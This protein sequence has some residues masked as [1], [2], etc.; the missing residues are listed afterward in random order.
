[1]K[2][3]IFN[4]Y[5]DKGKPSAERAGGAYR[6]AT[7]L[8][9][10]GWD[11]EVVDYLVYWNIEELTKLFD[12]RYSQGKI[13]WVG[14]S[15]TWNFRH[16]NLINL[17]FYIKR[18]YPDVK[19]IIGGNT[20]FNIDVKADYYVYGFGEYAADAILKYEFSNGTKPTGRPHWSG[21]AVDALSFYPAWPLDDYTLEYEDRDYL[22]PDDVVSVEIG[23]GCRFKCKYCNFPVLGLKEDTSMSEETM[24]K[25]FSSMYDRWGITTYNI[26]DE[27]VNER[28]SKLEKMS[29]AVQRCSFKPNFGA[30]TRLDLFNSHP[31][32]LELMAGARIWGQFYG[33]ET[34]NHRSGK[35]IGKGLDPEKNKQ[36]LLDTRKYM[37]DHVGLYRG[38]ASFI[39]GLPYETPDDLKSTHQWLIDN[40][41]DQNWTMWILTIPQEENFRLSA[42]G[43]DFSK[44]GYSK[45]SDQEIS[46]YINNNLDISMHAKQGATMLDQVIWKND[47]GNYFTF[48]GLAEK[49]DGWSGDVKSRDGNFGVWSKLS[50]GFSP[51]E[52]ISFRTD[53]D[54]GLDKQLA[55]AKHRAYINS[56]LS[57]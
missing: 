17:C 42:F 37:L 21:W 56:K 26:A 4:G 47:Q 34:F 30:F 41:T 57:K 52:A 25:Y 32:Q 35:I 36:L 33:V 14:F 22:K 5:N 43:E 44:Y 6:I 23:R 31:E 49:I 9:K 24:Y 2:A 10:S 18:V 20:N 54:H 13:S 15:S 8:R 39:A 19:I 46:Q 53:A 28:T 55:V 29:N 38:T 45:M 12:L 11:I 16:P 50:L 48:H 40:W 3:I 27:T 7:H 51:E 1:M